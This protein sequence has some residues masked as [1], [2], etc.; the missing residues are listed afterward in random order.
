MNTE[1]NDE[2]IVNTKPIHTNMTGKSQIEILFSFKGRMSRL[3]FW[4]RAFPF[5]FPYAIIV[6]MIMN[7]ELNSSGSVGLISL[8]FSLIGIY[9]TLAVWAKRIH[10]RNRSAW[11]LLI[12]LIPISVVWIFIEVGFLKGTDGEN[13]FGPDPAASS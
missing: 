9:P 10:D 6:I 11:F 1:T 3:E 2:P 5:L 8:V 4:G 12:L 13:R 7:S